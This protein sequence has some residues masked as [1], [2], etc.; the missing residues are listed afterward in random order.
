MNILKSC[1]DKGY[2][3][4]KDLLQ[5]LNS[6]S[7]IDLEISQEVLSVLLNI[8]REKILKKKIFLDNLNKLIIILLN[9]K[10]KREDK[11]SQINQ[12]IEF[13]NTFLKEEPIISIKTEIK[14][15][16]EKEEHE[17]KKG[18]KIISSPHILSKKIEVD[19]FV[20]HFRARFNTIK[21][22]LQDRNELQN[23]MSINK[24]SGQRQNIS[25]IG[26]IMGKRVTKNKNILL[27]VEDL[28]G[29]ISLLVN[30]NKEEVFA[31]ARDIVDD[32]MLGFK[33]SGNNEILFVNDI[34]FPDIFSKGKKTAEKEELA[35]F[36]SDLH[37]GSNKFLEKEFLRFLQWVNGE[38]GSAKQKEISKQIKY[39]FIIGDLVDGIGVYPGQEDELVIKDITEQYN[40]VAEFLS[41]IR[42]DITIIICSGNHDSVRIAE[43]QPLLDERFA[44]ALYKLPNILFV[45]NPS[46]VNIASSKTFPGLN[47]L[48]YHGYSFDYYANDVDT[49]RL[50]RAYHRPSLLI[51]F[52]LKRRHLAPTH[53]S[54]LYIPA[55][56]D[57]L[58][59]KEI[60]DV[61]VSAHIHKSD[62]SNYNGITTISCSCW[63]SK[64]PFQEKVGH[65]PD[66]CKVPILNLKSGQVS[67]ID[68]SEEK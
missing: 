60:P 61:F 31:K 20:K 28:T 62:V 46:V 10:E 18:V 5:I 52:L 41:K 39:L 7:Q 6:I 56:Q 21:S 43:P 66:P 35:L 38:I 24:I 19:D 1:I 57:A 30:Q 27:D 58:V 53:A 3:I 29:R 33:C 8:S 54:T 16:E 26:M 36:L 48:L 64:T 25:I 9:L 47:V 13:L 11:Q 59:I 4:E 32:D 68:F 67:I 14:K 44:S 55:E 45:S 50:N 65:E 63:Q 51:N 12:T 22:I 17:I 37:V 42:K 15:Q 34:V 49:L 2:L 40:K 23:L